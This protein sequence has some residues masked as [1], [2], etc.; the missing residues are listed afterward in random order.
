M[1]K[2][3]FTL[4]LLAV[5]FLLSC[6]S[7]ERDSVCDEK[8]IYYNGCVVGVSSSSGPSGGKGNNILNYRIVQIGNQTW[9]AENFNYVYGN[10]VCYNND[11]S[12]CTIYGRLYDWATA[13]ALP[14]MCNYSI[15]A[16]QIDAK[17][18]GICPVGW[19]IPSDAD[20]ATLIASVGETSTAGTKLKAMER[21]DGN[22]NGT[23][24]FGFAALPGGHGYS[25]SNV[26][27]SVG[28][29]GYW[30]SASEDNGDNAY[31]RSINYNRER[32]DLSSG[33]KIDL[34]SIRCVKD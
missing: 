14:S 15:C 22:G 32:V 21:W 20:W 23:D 24:E 8:S 17:H 30:W 31:Y 33:G 28:T 19:H 29:I 7:I 1:N 4:L 26:F 13:M 34:R 9:M 5:A 2:L 3:L 25:G 18:K 27:S 16:S 11:E 12:S 10:G 6:T